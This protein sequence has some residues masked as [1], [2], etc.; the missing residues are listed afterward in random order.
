MTTITIRNVPD[1]VRNALAARSAAAGQSMQ[2]YVLAELTHI[3]SR[4]DQREVLAEIRQRSRAY[5]PISRA[6][7]VADLNEDRR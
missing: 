3:A 5:P 6:A 1:E 2:E 4:V 7:I